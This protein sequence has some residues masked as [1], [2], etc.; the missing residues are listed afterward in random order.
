MEFDFYTN[1]S[2]V[3]DGILYRG[4]KNGV[5]IKRVEKYHPTLFVPTNEPSE[6][7]TLNGQSVEDI[8]PGTIKDCRDFVSRYDNV[9]NFTVYGN[10][11]YVYQYIGDNF[12][13]EVNY[14]YSQIPICYM[15][16]ETTCE[17]GFPQVENPM[18][19]VIAITVSMS[20]ETHVFGLGNF[21]TNARNTTT[22]TLRRKR[23]FFFT[24]LIGGNST[25]HI[26]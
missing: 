25:L 11:D 1:V 26:S 5:E 18:E 9:P 3:G 22:I 20:G 16:I 10:T 8:Q 6:F 15:D 7:K 17:R 21:K 12:P 2:L 19:A 4:M 23:I 13:T 14:D 24:S